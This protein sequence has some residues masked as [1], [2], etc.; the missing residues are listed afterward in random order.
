MSEDEILKPEYVTC[1]FCGSTCPNN[2][3]IISGGFYQY[4][5]INPKCDRVFEIL[6]AIADGVE[7][8]SAERAWL[9]MEIN[10][11]EKWIYMAG[12]VE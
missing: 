4:R 8:N 5:C 1:P 9:E 6:S 2:E 7:L 11:K 12:G 10:K 3:R